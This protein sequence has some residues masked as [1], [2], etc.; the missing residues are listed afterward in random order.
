MTTVPVTDL[1]LRVPTV[2]ETGG[3]PPVNGQDF[4]GKFRSA[5][6]SQASARNIEQVQPQDTTQTRTSTQRDEASQSFTR[7]G[8]R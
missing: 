5:I 2:N 8:K 1:G 3:T 4:M 6:E 7:Q